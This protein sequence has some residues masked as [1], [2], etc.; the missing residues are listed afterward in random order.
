[1]SLFHSIHGGKDKNIF[2]KQKKNDIFFAVNIILYSIVSIK[3][4]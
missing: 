2:L 1:M 3:P 4:V